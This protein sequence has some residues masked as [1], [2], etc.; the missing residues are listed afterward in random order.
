V[1]TTL[2]FRNVALVEVEVAGAGEVDRPYR[3]VPPALD[4]QSDPDA[5]M[6][7][8]RSS[9]HG[10]LHRRELSVAEFALTEMQMVGTE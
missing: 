9:V 6:H 10:V 1:G 3:T 8:G 7:G 5:E 4:N 2:S